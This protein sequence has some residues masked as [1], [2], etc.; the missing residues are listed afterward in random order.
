MK[1]NLKVDYADGSTA[2]AKVL[3]VDIVGFE[4]KFNRSAARLADEFRFTDACFLAWHA[5]NR[6]DPKAGTFDE[7]L[8]K[9][10]SVGFDEDE[11]E[12]VPLDKTA[13]TS[14]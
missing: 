7:W 5:L 14:D 9:I 13:P 12:I 1:M 8:L 6:S 2:E 3:A 10:D 11:G 4:T